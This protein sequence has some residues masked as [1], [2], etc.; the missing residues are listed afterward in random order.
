MRPFFVARTTSGNVPRVTS[1][2]YKTGELIIS[3]SP[4]VLDAN[5][6]LILCAADPAEVTGIALNKAGSTPGWDAANSPTVVTGRK[7]EL[8][9]ADANGDTI[10]GGESAAGTVPTKAHV[11]GQYGIAKD[12]NGVWGVD[13]TDTTNKVV[14]I[15]DIDIDRKLFFFKIME[16]VRTFGG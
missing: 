5:G 14:E 6:E 12:A 7:Q 10:Y 9:C 8:S 16:T 11:D 1:R 13:L 4:V 3:G 15:V 2:P